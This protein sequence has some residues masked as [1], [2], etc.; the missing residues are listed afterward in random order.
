MC[1]F[2]LSRR[3]KEDALEVS[4]EVGMNEKKLE[5]ERVGRM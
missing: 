4:V 3:E 2:S 1:C 5:V